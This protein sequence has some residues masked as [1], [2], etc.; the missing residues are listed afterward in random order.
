[1]EHNLFNL[2]EEPTAAPDVTGSPETPLYPR[3]IELAWCADSVPGN[4]IL[5]SMCTHVAAIKR[6]M[7]KQ[8]RLGR[9]SLSFNLPQLV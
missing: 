4:G 3:Q 5:R 7:K 1:M 6:P 9:S 2:P 8:N